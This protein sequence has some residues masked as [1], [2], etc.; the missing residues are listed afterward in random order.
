MDRR[1]PIEAF[2]QIG[3]DGGMVYAGDLKSLTRKGV[4]VRVLLGAP[5]KNDPARIVFLEVK[6]FRFFCSLVEYPL[7]RGADLFVRTMNAADPATGSAFPGE[8]FRAHD[9]DVACARPILFRV[10]N[11]A[12]PLVAREWREAFPQLAQLF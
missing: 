7:H 6:L 10:L 2:A 3:P 12:D 4:Q 11:P 1:L 9:F 5:R 8:H